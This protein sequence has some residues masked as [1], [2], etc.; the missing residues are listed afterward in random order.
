MLLQHGN[1][2][3]LNGKSG[4]EYFL[5]NNIKVVTGIQILNASTTVGEYQDTSWQLDYPN[6]FNRQNTIILAFQ[7]SINNSIDG[8][9]GVNPF[10][11][12]AMFDS[13]V[14]RNIGLRDDKIYVH[15]YNASTETKNYK[16]KIV[17]MKYEVDEKEY[18]LGDLNEDG[19]VTQEDLD[20][21]NNYFTK[22]QVLTAQQF[23]AAD[24]NKD[25]ILDTADTL[26]LS[27]YIN[28]VIDNL[29]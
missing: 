1:A 24:I 7:G 27:Q 17:F 14:P 26:K 4:N 21:L 9:Y 8:A 22:G 25:G 23:K 2:N 19:E 13:Y 5:K 18:T 11:S 16:Y 12:G 6:G 10:I 15:A 20:M 28:G 3:K 29:E